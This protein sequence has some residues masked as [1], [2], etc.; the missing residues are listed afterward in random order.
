MRFAVSIVVLAIA[1]P[2][3]AHSEQKVGRMVTPSYGT[4]H[5]YESCLARAVADWESM[6][7]IEPELVFQDRELN[8]HYQGLLGVL[9][10]TEQ[11]ALRRRQRAWIKKRDANCGPLW[12]QGTVDRVA[13]SSCMLNES[14]ERRNHLIEL[15]NSR[16]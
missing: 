7:C 6:E 3:I 1:S 11:R 4:S 15:A 5:A 12:D 9:S 16:P 8:R 13:Y 2:N 10:K 14:I